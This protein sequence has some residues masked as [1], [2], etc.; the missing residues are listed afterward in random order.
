MTELWADLPCIQAI[1]VGSGRNL[2]VTWANGLETTVD[3][4]AHINTYAVFVPLRHD[5]DVFG[6]VSVGEDGWNAH[7]GEDLEIAADTL[8]RLAWDRDADPHFT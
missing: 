7:W 6:A 3:V 5:P 1:R 2:V 8:W 4:G